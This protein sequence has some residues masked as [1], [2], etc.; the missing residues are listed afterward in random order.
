METTLPAL[1][2]VLAVTWLVPDVLVQVDYDSSA[3]TTKEIAMQL[4]ALGCTVEA[5][6]QMKVDG[7]HCRS[8]VE[9]IEGR[10]RELPGVV[11][12]RVSLEE[13]KAEVMFQ[14]LVITQQELQDQIE[15]MGFSATLMLKETS[16]GDL[17]FVQRDLNM[18]IQNTT[19][20][21]AGM[22]CSSCVQSIE[23]RISQT[24][25]V[26]SIVV[27]LKEE[28]ATISFDP[29]LTEP[30]QLWAA[31][32]DM[33]FDA[34]LKGKGRPLFKFRSTSQPMPSQQTGSI[35]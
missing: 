2:G 16:S 12:I 35:G 10:I 11:Q 27:S 24:R 30:E 20:W 13:A 15:D 25:G 34:S 8:C 1:D 9:S 23:G 3:T 5:A 33:G 17:T 21:I 29:G 26:K 22:S 7:M 18:S 19:I 14:P 28:K 31:I 4:Q 32:E 6:V